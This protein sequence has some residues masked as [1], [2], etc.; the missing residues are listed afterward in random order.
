[1]MA[2]AYGKINDFTARSIRKLSD[3]H[4]LVNGRK[5]ECTRLTRIPDVWGNVD[6]ETIS[7]SQIQAIFVFPPGEMPLIRLRA[8]KG[9]QAQTQSTNL[10]F[11]DILPTEIYVRWEDEINTGDVIY[12]FALDE[13]GNKMPVVFKIL[14]QKGAFSSQLIWRKMIAAPITSIEETEVPKDLAERLLAEIGS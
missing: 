12:F 6:S 5:T 11:Y 7:V 4:I 14:D 8:G 2:N 13:K 1:M 9:T 3:Y 10:F